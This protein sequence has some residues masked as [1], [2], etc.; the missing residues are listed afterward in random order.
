[1]FLA[2]DDGGSQRTFRLSINSLGNIVLELSTNGTTFG[3][4]AT[5]SATVTGTAFSR[6]W[7]RGTWRNSDGRTQFFTSTDGVVFVQLGVDQT[8]T[9]SALFDGT[10]ILEM[11]SRAT[12]IGTLMVGNYYTAALGT[13]IGNYTFSMDFGLLAKLATSGTAS[14]GQIVTINSTGDTGARICGARDLYQGSSSKRPIYTGPNLNTRL[15]MLFDGSNDYLKSAPFSLSQPETVYLV[16]QQV[17]WSN[18]DSIFDGNAN[19]S[20]EIFQDTTTPNI[21]LYAGASVTNTRWILNIN[22]ILT[23]IFNSTSSLIRINRD[24][25]V[26]GNAGT[27]NGG[28]FTLGAQAGGSLSGN[29]RASE[30]AIYSEAHNIVNQNLII[31]YFANKYGIS[32]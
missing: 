1:M 2:K 8:A 11:G 6:L 19:D 17:T 14:T 10:A 7:C 18:G 28:G 16:G 13:T 20:M 29:I 30:V 5:S 3:S 9:T 27:A 15:S 25:A 21:T 22:A 12:G 24:F 23:A 26:G 4:T 31:S 32:I